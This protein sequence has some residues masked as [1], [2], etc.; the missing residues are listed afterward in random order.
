MSDEKTK[1]ELSEQIDALTRHNKRQKKDLDA[2]DTAR[3]DLASELANHVDINTASFDTRGS[4]N[5]L[6]S[7]IQKKL[8]DYRTATDTKRSDGTPRGV[9]AT[10]AGDG[11][12]ALLR[13]SLTLANARKTV[14]EAALLEAGIDP[15]TV[16]D[17]E[18]EGFRDESH[19]VGGKKVKGA[20]EDLAEAFS[21][22]FD[23][24]SR[25]DA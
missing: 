16:K 19:G 1:S 21:S 20:A 25:D 14:L 3:K 2:A 5:G 12:A 6:V 22:S 15:I 11:E 10:G 4:W 18:P 23:T 24:S 9:G 8:R 7:S 17:V 13:E